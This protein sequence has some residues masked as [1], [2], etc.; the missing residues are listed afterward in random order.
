MNSRKKDKFKARA[1]IMK[2]LAH[3]S[4]LFIVEELNKGER[5]VRELTT[6]IGSDTSTVSKHLSILRNAGIVRDEKRANMVF[7]HLT[8]KCVLN[9]F[10]CIEAVMKSTVAQQLDIINS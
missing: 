7:Y 5:S 3:P 9:F 6:M 4:R 1:K 2:A 8:A 10:L